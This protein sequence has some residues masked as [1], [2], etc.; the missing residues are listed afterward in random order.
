M[1]KSGSSEIQE[2][3]LTF[4]FVAKFSQPKFETRKTFLLKKKLLSSL[5]VNFETPSLTGLP[6][7]IF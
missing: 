1:T 2:L 6:D 3:Q 4:G 7:V 5:F